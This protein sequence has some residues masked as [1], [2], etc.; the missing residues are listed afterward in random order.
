MA[1]PQDGAVIATFNI[2][3][4]LEMADGTPAIKLAA[5]NEVKRGITEQ[6]EYVNDYGISDYRLQ[7][8]EQLANVIHEAL[9]PIIQRRPNRSD[10]G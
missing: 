3:V 8:G 6:L 5:V 7:G 2:E 9:A 10:K 1:R 4:S